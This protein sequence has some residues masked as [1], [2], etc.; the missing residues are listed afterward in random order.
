MDQNN[1]IEF[2]DF[3]DGGVSG[4]ETFETWRQKTNGII[5]KV[6]IIDSTYAVRSA[7]L[8]LDSTHQNVG[9]NKTFNGVRID[10]NGGTVP[11]TANSQSELV[12]TNNVV[13]GDDKTVSANSLICRGNTLSIAG[14]PY[15]FPAA[16]GAFEGYAY[17]N[18]QGEIVFKDQSEIVTAVINDLAQATTNVVATKNITPIGTVIAIRFPSN[19]ATPDELIDDMWL[20]CNG[21]TFL[22]TDYPE[23]FALLGGNT[24]PN[25]TGDVLMGAPGATGP[26]KVVTEGATGADA[27]IYTYVWYYIKARPDSVTTFT[28]T[29]GDGI[30]LN[31]RNEIGQITTN[32]PINIYGGSVSLNVGNEFAFDSSSKTLLLAN[33]SI[34]HTKLT[35]ANTAITTGATG[36]VLRDT[37]GHIRGNTPGISDP[38]GEGAI[39]TNKA[40]VDTVAGSKDY[41]I[42]SLNG[43]GFNSYGFQ[44]TYGCVFINHDKRVKVYGHN[45]PSTGNRYGM[46]VTFDANGHN[47]PLFDKDVKKVYSDNYNTYI[48]YNDDTVYSYGF[49]TRRKTGI[50]SLSA[51]DSGA[52]L[53]G[54]REAFGGDSIEEVILSYDIA[55]ETVYALTKDGR[56]WVAGS[57]TNGQLGLN[58]TTPT[59]TSNTYLPRVSSVFG[60]TIVKAWL[61][62]GGVTQT[63]YALADDKTL[64]ACGYGLLGQMGRHT[65]TQSNPV[66][67]PVLNHTSTPYVGGSTS[68]I[69]TTGVYTSTN[70]HDLQTYD[71]IRI[72]TANYVV[73][74]L[75][76]RTFTL[77]AND[78]LT[79]PQSTPLVNFTTA[80]PVWK[81]MVD[82]AD[83]AFGGTGANTFAYVQKTDG[84]LYAWGSNGSG[85]LGINSIANTSIPT[86]VPITAG[87]AVKSS[88]VYTGLDNT[89]HFISTTGHL[90]A[91]GSNA[92]GLLGIN[93]SAPSVSS[94]QQ[95]T[96]AHLNVAS[97]LPI[98][99]NNYSVY[100]FFSTGT[101]SRFCIF[102]SG[103]DKKLTAWGSNANNKLGADNDAGSYSAPK[104]V[105]I[106]NVNN[107]TDIQTSLLVSAA[108]GELTTILIGDT[109]NSGF[110]D[111]HTCGYHY[112]NI[113][114]V[115]HGTVLPYFTKV[116]NI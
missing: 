81:R 108:G 9:Q 87:T 41:K 35:N 23:L 93:S 102:E 4:S 99:N 70:D 37:S 115:T 58:I 82:I 113:N 15:T 49:N 1:Y 24:L 72:G 14:K 55:A 33:G 68:R 28:I 57:N 27:S 73:N 80:T 21:D 88:A 30:T 5:Q 12:L 25:F 47:L 83:A 60:K 50:T 31:G 95:I 106:E 75:T 34:S 104:H 67:V 71:V 111:L 116:K 85:Q 76:F 42:R 43:R 109:N 38:S 46:M 98:S 52:A 8:L 51:T 62:G 11:I 103:N 90:Y 66:W 44:P 40:Y 77:H 54:P 29:S 53:T 92:F 59:S 22:Q 17:H 100:K 114:N 107:V 48:L 32:S 13:V 94:F 96:V 2:N 45:A 74:V 91:C 16:S 36:I 112:Y 6:G 20:L 105:Y 10:G 79:S 61:I 97:R 69:S 64:W 101:N 84:T 89:V 19:G 39:L 86:L 56:L 78:L 65:L 3:K 26:L 18:P 7:T 63:G 110:G